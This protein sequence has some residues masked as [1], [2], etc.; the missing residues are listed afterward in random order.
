MAAVK[1][2][3]RNMTLSEIRDS[4]CTVSPLFALLL[5]IPADSPRVVKPGGNNGQADPA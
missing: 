5:G 2:P 3:D 4:D 1:P